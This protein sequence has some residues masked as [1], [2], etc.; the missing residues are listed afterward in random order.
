MKRQLALLAAAL[1]W[2]ACASAQDKP[3][4]TA[5]VKK[6]CHQ[7]TAFEKEVGYCNT[8]R[9]GNTLYVS[10]AAAPGPMPDA[11]KNVYGS[12]KRTLASHGLTLAHVVKETVYATDLDAFIKHQAMRKAIYG[13]S[14]PAA[15]WVQVTRLYDP[16]LVL[17]VEVTAVF[18]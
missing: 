12:L 4:D 8:V 1:A 14:Y 9:I 7:G 15:T 17:E 13:D 10:G 5:L 2:S 18:P 3:A 16:S 11:V 6:V